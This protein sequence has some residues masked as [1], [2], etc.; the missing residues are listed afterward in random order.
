MPGAATPTHEKQGSLPN[1]ALT[2]YNKIRM[3][4]ESVTS[5]VKNK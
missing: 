4:H 2:N 5:N 3:K 1:Q